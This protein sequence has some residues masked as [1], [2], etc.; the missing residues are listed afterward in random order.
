MTRRADPNLLLLARAVGLLGP[1][2]DRMVFLGGCATTLLL[3]DPGAPEV[4]PTRDVDVITEVGSLAEYYR[5][6]DELRA[7]GFVEDRSPGAPLCR[8]RV[9]DVILDVMPTDERILGFGNRWYRPA[10]VTAQGFV[11]PGGERIRVVTAPYFLAT[12]LEAFAGRG[13]GDYLASP[14]LEDIIT[15]IDGRPGV[16]EEVFRIE[17]A[18]RQ[19]VAERFSLL[20]G[21]RSFLEAIPAHLPPDAASQG[22]LPILLDRL[23]RLAHQ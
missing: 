9:S 11:L 14:D 15:L 13:R 12:K 20:L 4:R 21:I 7:A 16:V 5:L 1:L 22:R 3:T 2:A 8:W 23:R 10:L 17:T 6:A 19:Y 18:L